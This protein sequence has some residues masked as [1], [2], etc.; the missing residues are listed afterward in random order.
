VVPA[1]YSIDDIADDALH[2]LRR[3]LRAC[4]CTPIPRARC[5]PI[6]LGVFLDR[7]QA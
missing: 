6:R 5:G 4:R 2:R 3:L 7:G 1:Q